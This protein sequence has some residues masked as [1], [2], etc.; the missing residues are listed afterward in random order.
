MFCC[1]V[2]GA[3]PNKDVQMF[4]VLLIASCS[5][6]QMPPPLATFLRHGI[7]TTTITGEWVA[8]STP[9]QRRFI[10]R[11]MG[12]DVPA[13]ADMY[14]VYNIP[15]VVATYSDMTSR[16]TPKYDAIHM[17]KGTIILTN[18]SEHMRQTLHS[19]YRGRVDTHINPAFDAI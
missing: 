1:N 2:V 7:D 14:M 15:V 11:C 4:A 17:N 3:V 16:A 10:L 13:N 19:R 9:I 5:I 8:V 18:C 12:C 6:T